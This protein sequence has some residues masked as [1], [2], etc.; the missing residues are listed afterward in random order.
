M[1]GRLVQSIVGMPVLIPSPACCSRSRN[2][3]AGFMKPNRFRHPLSFP[4]E[5]SR[6]GAGYGLPGA[7]FIAFATKTPPGVVR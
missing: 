5:L 6:R 7:R 4:T 3:L 2:W 1:F